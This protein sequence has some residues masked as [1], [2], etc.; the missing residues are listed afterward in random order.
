MRGIWFLLGLAATARGAVVDSITFT[1]TRQVDP[2]ALRR[3]LP[4]KRGAEYTTGSDKACADWLRGLGLFLDVQVAG[5]VDGEAVKVRVTVVENPNVKSVSFSGSNLLAWGT[6]RPELQTRPDRLLDRR[7]LAQDALYITAQFRKLG[8]VVSVEAKFDQPPTQSDRPVAVTFDIVQLRAG[9]LRYETLRYVKPAALDALRLLAP[10][11]PLLLDRLVA[12]QRKLGE[13]PLLRGVGE[14][15]VT[16]DTDQDPATVDVVFP[17]DEIELPLLTAETLPLVDLDRL[18][19]AVRFDMVDVSISTTDL[20][21]YRPPAVLAAGLAG[22]RDD[23]ERCLWQLRAG[24]DPGKLLESAAATLNARFEQAPTAEDGLAL[25]RLATWTGSRLAA[26][27]YCERGLAQHPDAA[28]GLALRSQLIGLLSTYGPGQ[29]LRE[30]CARA[31]EAIVALP[32]TA[33]LDTVTYAFRCY[34]MSLLAAPHDTAMRLAYGLDSPVAGRLVKLVGEAGEL[35]PKGDEAAAK[36]AR[37][38]GLAHLGK[39]LTAICLAGRLVPTEVAGRPALDNYLALVG[40]LTTNWLLPA[41]QSD[42]PRGPFFLALAYR[43]TGR[44]GSAH[45]T[46]LGNLA[47]CPRD[48]RLVDIAVECVVPSAAT[49]LDPKQAAAAID[50]TL[51]SLLDDRGE[52]KVQSWSAAMLATKL[53]LLWRALAP[54]LPAEQREELRAGAAGMARQARALAPDLSGGALLQGHAE[55]RGPTPLAAVEAYEQVLK[56]VPTQGEAKYGRALALL[57]GGR[58]AEGLAAMQALLPPKPTT[59]V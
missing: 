45:R 29:K 43:C 27:E 19:Q 54:E 40:E 57:V 32:P 52:L 18:A 12:Q 55:L 20:E 44:F 28:V 9:Q 2:E 33:N 38:A 50:Q 10:R 42:D 3:H 37:A 41:A 23:Y 5:Q 36:A 34:L 26:I 16:E 56:L 1:G 46:V 47:R 48:E 53:M 49:G 58:Q 7:Q 17:V 8:A 39:C 21:L 35:L 24:R 31:A 15:R 4:L 6:L 22:A 11:E 30:S 25:A 14:P 59:G 13:L 51:K